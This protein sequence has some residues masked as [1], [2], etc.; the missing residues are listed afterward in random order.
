MIFH[1]S[2]L[3]QVLLFLTYVFLFLFLPK[4]LFIHKLKFGSKKWKKLNCFKKYKL[5]IILCTN[6]VGINRIFF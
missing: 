5:K 4:I 1:I 2:L 3:F 6:Y